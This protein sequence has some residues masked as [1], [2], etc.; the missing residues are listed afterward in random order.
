[1]ADTIED[2]IAGTMRDLDAGGDGSGDG[3]TETPP[4]PKPTE[5]D[6]GGGSG[7]GTG[8]SKEKVPAP[9][10]TD[11]GKELKEDDPF[12]AEHG[13]KVFDQRKRENR[14]PYSAVKRMTTTA[15]T[16][17]KKELAKLVLGKDPDEAK[18]ILEQVKERITALSGIETEH[19]SLKEYQT[20]YESIGK[21]MQTE[22]ERFLKI[23]PA[24]NAK[25]S[26]LLTAVKAAAGTPPPDDKPKPDVDLGDGKHTY[27]P[28]Q[29]AKLIQ[30]EVSQAIKADRADRDKEIEPLKRRVEVETRVADAKTRLDRML[31][32]ARKNWPG[33]KENEPEIRK[34]IEEGKANSLYDGHLLVLQA[35][36]DAEL[37]KRE[38]DREKIRK[39]L[40]E[41]A[42][43]AAT[44]TSATG[45]AA[46]KKAGDVDDGDS[47][48]EDPIEK[49]IRE[50][51]H[52]LDRK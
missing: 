34:V 33:F 24:V 37:K 49:A 35:K 42:K 41:E 13:I 50:T 3:G 19:K 52:E 38:T 20:Q 1:M 8:E 28:D 23:L 48:D 26:E 2:I 30:Y 7:D 4:D 47:G 10:S 43:N 39:E 14:I 21:I 45:R 32:S 18:D 22:P 36:H 11:D 16:K 25:Y 46:A 12:A 44:S 5:N 51:I 15:T 29:M 40:M 27:S 9:T 17:L 31:E 6:G